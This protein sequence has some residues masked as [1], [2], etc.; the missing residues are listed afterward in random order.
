MTKKNGRRDFMKGKKFK[1]VFVAALSV[2]F[3]LVV[4][5]GVKA[6]A[7]QITTITGLSGSDA[8]VTN[9]QGQKVDPSKIVGDGQATTSAITGQFQMERTF[10]MEIL[11]R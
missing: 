3:A 10:Q 2:V 8:T 7:F 9:S 5:I 11:Q 6:Y 4:G 1:K